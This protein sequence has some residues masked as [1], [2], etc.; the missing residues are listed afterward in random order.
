MKKLLSTG[1]FLAFV[2]PLLFSTKS[3]GTT[4][5]SVQDSSVV[6]HPKWSRN[7]TIYEINERQFSKQGTFRAIIPQLPRLKKMGVKIIWLMPINPIGKKNR[8]GPLGSYYSVQNY[9]KINPHYGTL[10]DLKT[11]VNAIHK[12]GM[13]VIIDWV[14]N[15]TSWDN[16]LTKTHPDWYKHDKNGNFVPPVKD[17]TDVIKLDYSKPGLRRYMINAMEYWVKTANIDG[18][19]CDVASMVPIDFWIQARKD[20]DKIK[21]VFMLAEAESPKMHRAFDMTYGWNLYHLFND[22][23]AGK[24][25][26]SDIEPLLKKENQTYPRDAYRMLFTSNHDENSWN[27]TVFERLKGGAKTFAVLTATMNGMPLV[28]DGQEA[29]MRKRLKFFQKDPIIWRKSSF[30]GFYTKLLHLKEQNNALLNGDKG[31]AL[32]IIQNDKP[33][34]VFAFVREK[35]EQKVVVITNLTNQ[36]QYVDLQSKPM[37]GTYKNLFTG[38]KQEISSNLK[39]TLKPWEFIILEKR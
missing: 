34:A 33:K 30:S 32:Q 15:H 3:Y 17:W 1:L 8:K 4:R 14:A 24:K 35:D 39:I 19:R 31:G 21:P 28:Y 7:A 5:G 38:K 9:L 16:V 23:A 20:L 10:G 6:V 37:Q 18:F 25:N 2:I 29:G 27:G 11:L 22:I 13:H 12:E 26:A 36:S